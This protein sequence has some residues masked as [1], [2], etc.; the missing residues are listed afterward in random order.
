MSQYEHVP[1]YKA[2]FDLEIPF[3]RVGPTPRVVA[4]KGACP[5]EDVGGIGVY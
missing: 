5:P 1:I 3:R 4:G 2:A